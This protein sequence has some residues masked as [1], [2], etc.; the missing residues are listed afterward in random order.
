MTE[1][2]NDHMEFFPMRPEFAFTVLSI[3]IFILFIQD[4]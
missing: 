2:Q 4:T 1:I 3:K